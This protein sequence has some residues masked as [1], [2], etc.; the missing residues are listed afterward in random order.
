M[1]GCKKYWCMYMTKKDV[2]IPTPI[3]GKS[4]KKYF[5]VSN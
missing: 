3:Q 1:S 4:D 2:V 5:D